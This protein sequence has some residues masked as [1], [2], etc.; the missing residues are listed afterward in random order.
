MMPSSPTDPGPFQ[1]YLFSGACYVQL[2]RCYAE[3]LDLTARSGDAAGYSGLCDRLAGIW[4]DAFLCQLANASTLP[5]NPLTALNPELDESI[6]AHMDAVRATGLAGMTTLLEEL[7]AP[8]DGPVDFPTFFQNWLAAC[9]AAYAELVRS[10]AFAQII[11]LV[12]NA[13]ID[14]VSAGTPD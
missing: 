6:R 2:G 9:D 1:K 14:L 5:G 12:T 4:E 11:G 13:C 10:P 7:K 8:E 3:Y